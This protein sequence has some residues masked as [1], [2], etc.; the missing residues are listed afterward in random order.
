MPLP[1]ESDNVSMLRAASVL[2]ITSTILL[3]TARLN[4]G[5]RSA[6][7]KNPQQITVYQPTG[8]SWVFFR[9]RA[10][11]YWLEEE[12]QSVY[13]TSERSAPWLWLKKLRHPYNH[14]VQPWA[15]SHR[16]TIITDPD[17][18][19][20]AVAPDGEMYFVFSDR[21]ETQRNGKAQ[22]VARDDLTGVSGVAASSRS[23]FVSD[24]NTNRLFA[25]DRTT[26][27][28]Y[29]IYHGG[30]VPDRLIVSNQYLY[31]M[32]YAAR[33]L[34]RYALVP[35]VVGALLP[36]TAT[37]GSPVGRTSEQLSLATVTSAEDF[38]IFQNT[39]YILEPEKSRVTAVS[40]RGGGAH[41]LNI[42]GLLGDVRTLASTEDGLVFSDRETHSYEVL[43]EITP[44]TLYTVQ[45]D[46]NAD[47]GVL[48]DYLY[49]RH[50]LPYTMLKVASPDELSKVLLDRH[51]V[52]RGKTVFC[53]LND[54]E[55]QDCEKEFRFPANVS[56]PDLG[57]ESYITTT[58]VT[59]R[60]DKSAASSGPLL[61]DVASVKFDGSPEQLKDALWKANDWYKGQDITKEQAGNFALP[62]RAVE[63]EGFVSSRERGRRTTLLRKALSPHSLLQ[64]PFYPSPQSSRAPFETYH[65]AA[66]QNQPSGSEAPSRDAA[67]FK[68]I[69]AKHVEAAGKIAV[70]DFD[71]DIGHPLFKKKQFEIYSRNEV[72]QTAHEDGQSELGPDQPAQKIGIEDHGT[73]IAGLIGGQSFAGVW[74]G[75]NPGVLIEGVHVNDF[76]DTVNKRKYH[77]YNLSLGEGDFHSASDVPKFE[78]QIHENLDNWKLAIRNDPEDLFIVAAGNE[79]S[80]L[81]DK[82]LAGIGAEPN[83][84]TVMATD[85]LGKNIWKEDSSAGT[86]Y[87]K[88]FVGIAAPGEGLVS[89]TYH[90][91]W[92]VASGTSQATALVAAAASIIRSK[93]NFR[94]WQIKSRLIASSNVD[95]WLQQYNEFSLGGV[96]D[97]EKAVTN[98]DRTVVYFRNGGG[99]CIGR[100]YTDEARRELR[101][102]KVNS[103]KPISFSDI[104]RLHWDKAN[105]T[106]QIW[107]LVHPDND[108]SQSV[109]L[110]VP[111]VP[112][113]QDFGVSQLSGSTVN[114][115][116]DNGKFSIEFE[117][118]GNCAVAEQT[119]TNIDDLYGGF[120]DPL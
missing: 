17:L 74:Y 38:A 35:G 114:F 18:S 39:V 108:D 21:I 54:S 40:F 98:A 60:H 99:P 89:G 100:F 19:T 88:S 77:I 50:L 70:V 34:V 66:S 49:E 53:L 104:L 28:K 117:N 79:N 118:G 37:G 78:G 106:F 62:V 115:P 10:R 85:L 97:V 65:S 61:G 112:Q 101:I 33:Q 90:G 107:Y 73:H 63:V 59:L 46:V 80:H 8:R 58:Q 29:T 7:F 45:P 105:Q 23:I 84:L 9:K 13:S 55:R 111:V 86:N 110:R 3:G 102:D 22:V 68:A 94:S 95:S 27:G 42:D 4:A 5:D 41:A 69:D 24:A 76:I 96:L 31:G 52:D 113:R 67:W 44:A 25:I 93:Y 2:A 81:L 72:E 109:M 103:S 87:G 6:L 48:Y 1:L 36:E 64:L 32:N 83:A 15:G 30:D 11:I 16:K 57:I 47:V 14:H 91:G 26:G 92:A 56:V 20:Y 116:A 43:T 71:F 120:Y 119:L 75:L 12:D 82:R 51:L